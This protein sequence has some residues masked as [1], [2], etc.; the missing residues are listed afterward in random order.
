MTT[1]N[2]DL[3]EF[4]DALDRYGAN[5]ENWPQQARMQALLA[6]SPVARAHLAAMART[7]A[8]LKQ[9]RMIP[10]PDVSE[11]VARA[12]RHRQERPQAVVVRRLSWAGA[13]AL[14]LAI[15]IF[16]GATPATTDDPVNVVTA[17]LAQ[18][19]GHDVW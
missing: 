18:T 12:M 11:L 13:G 4:L 16:V 10:M 7:E 5:L 1:D 14:A 19:D 8:A 9:T 15:G 6:R 3:E 17:A 2:A